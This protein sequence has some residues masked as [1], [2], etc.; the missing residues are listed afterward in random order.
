[1]KAKLRFHTSWLV[2]TLMA[3]LATPTF[4]LLIGQT[5]RGTKFLELLAERGPL[6]YVTVFFA[7]WVCSALVLK[8]LQMR[9]QNKVW[10]HQ[11]IPEGTNQITP[12]NAQG[13]A[14]HIEKLPNRTSQSLLGQ[15]L[16]KGLESCKAGHGANEIAGSMEAQSDIDARASATGF[17][18]VKVLLAAIPI[19]GFIGTVLGIGSA[20]GGFGQTMAGAS[21]LGAI[22]ESLGQVTGGLSVAFD[23]T[24]LALVTSVLLMLPMSFCQQAEDRMLGKMDDFVASEFVVRLVCNNP[25]QDTAEGMPEAAQVQLLSEAISQNVDQLQA[26]LNGHTEALYG[27]GS[28]LITSLNGMQE[29]MT[30]T[31]Q[32]AVQS[33]EQSNQSARAQAEQILQACSEQSERLPRELTEVFQAN[34]NQLAQSHREVTGDLQGQVRDILAQQKNETQ[35]HI[36]TLADCQARESHAAAGFEKRSQEVLEQVRA[37]YQELVV[38]QQQI[39][40][41][42]AA[43]VEQTAQQTAANRELIPSLGQA[44]AAQVQET[45]A[46]FEASSQAHAERITALMESSIKTLEE[47][48]RQN[49]ELLRHVLKQ[50]PAA[51]QASPAPVSPARNGAGSFWNIFNWGG[52][53]HATA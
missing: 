27:W 32:W 44:A 19:L 13:I 20:V 39:A 8:M 35:L 22:K 38:P 11:L 6:Q 7:F 30:Q 53:K 25:G 4:Y 2:P 49:S 12:E 9:G 46:H 24:L 43:L 14:D 40:A 50:L 15:R 21:E 10:Q 23:T 3:A 18:T 17:S 41:S 45:R 34:L 31:Q 51:G 42:L 36:Q 48:S 16:L 52:K 28:Q 5:L 33:I 37:S 1:M 26:S 47:Q 29:S